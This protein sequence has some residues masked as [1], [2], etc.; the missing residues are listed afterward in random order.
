MAT[1]TYKINIDVESKTLGQLEDELAQIN[2]ELKQVDRNSQAFTELSKKSQILT[3]EIEKTN[4]AIDGIQL[5]DKIQAADGAIKVLGGSLSATI[6]ALGV[7]GVES[8]VFGKFEERAASAIA[9][10]M[11]IKDVSE[12]FGQF[13]MVMKKSGIAAK[14]FGNTTKTA[15]VATGIGAFV[16]ALG[17]VVTYWDDITK[18]VKKAAG[19]FPFVG[20][21]IDTIK[22]QFNNLVDAFRPVLEFLGILPDEA[23]RA[24]MAVVEANKVI[25]EEGERE[26]ALAQARKASAEELFA[27][28]ERLAIAEIERLRA[29]GAEKDEIF[30]AETELLALQIAEQTRLKEEAAE[31][32][33]QRRAEQLEERQKEIEGFKE[34]ADQIDQS[35][36]PLGVQ[37]LKVASASDQLKDSVKGIVPAMTEADAA[38]FKYTQSQKAQAQ[39]D[40]DNREGLAATG[41]ALGQL[42]AVLD[43]ESTAAKALA[44]GSAII[45]TYL[46]ISEVLRQP[47]VLPSP[48]DLITKVANVATIAATGFKAVQG[49][50]STSKKG[51]GGGGSANVAG[52]RGASSAAPAAPQRT[53][54]VA[55]TFTSEQTAPAIK[56]YV[57][58][59]DVRNEEEAA[60]KINN[61]RTVA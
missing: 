12:G 3:S 11:G 10:G 40:A 56:A 48:F 2:D 5:E 32:E 29:D 34:V 41:Q 46:G 13:T 37:T 39:Q 20:K 1:K 6:G 49:I 58:G 44:I 8:E 7:I 33:K 14:L 61:R 15:L 4:N 43:Q 9:V 53:P 18:A 23:E 59:G 38:T 31:A 36:E 27:I 55:Q 21:A 16:V 52:G 42:G 22:E 35:L 57:V 19:S 54:D 28:K 45:N 60:A 25:L 50:K 30:K 24:A 17:L 51:G 47:S 26:L